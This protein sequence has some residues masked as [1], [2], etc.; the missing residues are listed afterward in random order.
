MSVPSSDASL[1][2]LLLQLWSKL[3]RRRRIQL[4][5]LLILML[6]SSASEVLSLA[7]VMPFLAVLANPEVFWQQSFVQQWAPLMGIESAEALLLPVTTAF[8][9]ASLLAGSVRLLNLWLNG[10]LAAAIGSDL[11]CEAFRRTLYQPYGVHLTRNSSD[12]I[13]SI[14]NDVIR[15]IDLVLNPLLLM[16][17]SGLVV[18]GLVITLLIINAAVALGAGLVVGL[19]YVAAI[20]ANRHQ[21]QKLGFR[22]LKL[23][24]RLIKVLQEGLGAIRDV[25]LDGH[26]DFYKDAYVKT[27]RQLRRAGADSIFLSSYPR[28][29]LEPLGIALI[30][31]IGFV[32]V[33]QQGVSVALPLLGALALGAQRL[34]PMAQK[35]YEG[36][37]QSRVAKDSLASILQLL[38]Q[39]LPVDSGLPKATALHLQKSIRFEGVRFRYGPNL[40]EVL[41]GL[42]LEICRGERIGL[43]GS[44]G[45]GKSTTI[46]LFL[47]LLQPTSGQILVDGSNLHGASQV[48]HL[49]AWRAAIAHV[50]QSIYLADRS[51]AENIAF[52]ERFDQIDL[53]RVRKAAQ[54]AQIDGFIESSS[55]GYASF[56]GERYSVKWRTETAYRH[57]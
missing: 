28:L 5:V 10:R 11:S 21:L 1:I 33:S 3:A 44:T 42:D 37:A 34:L 55:E 24:R 9:F 8:V 45:S 52:G 15:V 39:P 57:C 29:V 20:A 2:Q 13:S 17:S 19:V 7:A 6:A 35:V 23:N 46:D 4:G 25:L 31:S 53:Q 41:K 51:I 18:I 12:L 32:L 36:W 27:D 40:P 56:V 48:G 30:A 43:I 26:Q 50:P 16:L 14:S 38:A 49:S 54:Q 22:Q 47:G